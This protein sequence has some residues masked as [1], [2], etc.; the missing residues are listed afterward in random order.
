MA[1]DSR[2]EWCGMQRGSVKALLNVLPD[3]T[4]RDARSALALAETLVKQV[5][6]AACMLQQSIELRRRRRSSVSFYERAIDMHQE[7]PGTATLRLEQVSS[8][9]QDSRKVAPHV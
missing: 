8:F 1:S 9:K 6:C 4:G 7:L 5:G 3:P 2:F